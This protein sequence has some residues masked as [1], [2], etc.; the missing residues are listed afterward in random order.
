MTSVSKI[1]IGDN[2]T[3]GWIYVH[4]DFTFKNG[5]LCIKNSTNRIKSHPCLRRGDYFD[6]IM[7]M[8]LYHGS[9]VAVETPTIDEALRRLL[10]Q[11]LRDQFAFKTEGALAYL[12]F[13]EAIRV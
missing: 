7:A 11:R 5:T 3:Y 12:S 1:W 10:P 6:I 2:G 9:N 13:R 4:L 8:T